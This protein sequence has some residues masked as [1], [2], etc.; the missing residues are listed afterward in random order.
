MQS[1]KGYF[2]LQDRLAGRQERNPI[3]EIN[4]EYADPFRA[5]RWTTR[6]RTALVLRLIRGASLPRLAERAGLTQS[7]L[8]AW[9][10]AYLRG[11]RNALRDWDQWPHSP[12]PLQGRRI[13]SRS[14]S[15]R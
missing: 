6:K 3:D 4:R 7:R 10:K 12:G 15:L 8:L 5:V 2:P 9:K 13:N 14:A 11:G 1:E